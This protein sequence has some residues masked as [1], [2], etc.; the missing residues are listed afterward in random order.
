MA[1]KTN[2]IKDYFQSNITTNTYGTAIVIPS[3][4]HSCEQS[5]TSGLNGIKE[6]QF[7]RH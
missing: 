1:D 6:N 5:D 7:H 4:S 2:Y 3:H